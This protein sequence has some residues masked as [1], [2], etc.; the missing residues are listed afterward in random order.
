MGLR[1]FGQVFNVDF[2]NFSGPNCIKNKIG[3][4]QTSFM[5]TV[6]LPPLT[7]MAPFLIDAGV[8]DLRYEM[9]WGKP[10]AFAYDQIAG[11]ATNPI[12]DF[13]RLDSFVQMLHTNG[14]TPLFAMGYDPIPLKNCTDWQCWKDVPNDLNSWQGVLKQYAAHYSEILGSKEFITRSGMSR[15]CPA[16]AARYFSTEI[17]AIMAIFTAIQ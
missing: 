2:S 15:I 8:C 17:K 1:V 5:G 3:V 7:S 16:M 6:G 11:V 10:D 4:Y 9:G 13:S 12:I 14:I